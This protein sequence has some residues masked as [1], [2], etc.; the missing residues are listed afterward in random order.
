M[1]TNPQGG[2]PKISDKTD[3]PKDTGYVLKGLWKYVSHYKVHLIAAIILTLCSNL[4]ALVGPMLSGYAIDAIQP[5]KGLVVFQTVLYYAGWMIAFYIVSSVLSYILSVLMIRFSQKIIHKMREDLFSKLVELPVSFFDRNQA[6]DIIS[7]FSYDIDTINTSLSS[8]FIQVCTSFITVFGSLI[9]MIIIS[10]ILVLVMLVTIP[11]SLFYTRYMAK[12]VR[13]LFRTRS[14]KLGELNGFVEEMVS[15]QMTIKAYAAEN[16]VMEKFGRINKETVDAYFE[17][18]YYGSMTGPT[19]NFINNLSLS[20][21]TVLGAVLYLFGKMTLGNISSFVQY[22][23][24]FS[25]PIN[26]MAN[27][28]SELQSA[29]AAAERVFKLMDE[30]P[31]LPDKENANELSEVKGEV[32]MEGVSFGYIPDKEIIKN[33]FL[34]ARPGCLTAIVGPT[35]AG[36]TTIINLLMRFYDIWGGAI[37]V[38]GNEIRDVTR[39]SL[40]RS[41]AM[42]LQDT[43]LFS[44]TIFDNIAYGKENATMDEVVAAAKAAG[45][46]SYIKRLPQGYYTVINEDGMN[47]SKGQKQLLTIAR[48]MLMDAKMLILDEATSNVDTRTEIKIQKAMRKLM[49]N[50]TCFVIAHRLST[51]QGA[52]NI[53]VVDQ[54]DVVE[55]GTHKELMEKKGFYYKLYNSQ[56]E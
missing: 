37:W 9:M 28:I 50:K 49:E 42:V 48:A 2:G 30:I 51:I 13:P 21:I 31:E 3:K 27:I 39:K 43:W 4:L 22:S 18:E 15:G 55:Q 38:D 23:R 53:L 24:K 7:K 19:V 35:G 10:P 34:Y 20:L 8:D 46:H 6:G 14:K 11:L 16:S 52:D 12:K 25:G 45:I 44:G 29:M 41:Y 5:G 33:L 56:F 17:A 54:G 26:E 32:K 47:I 40:R 36:K 1:A